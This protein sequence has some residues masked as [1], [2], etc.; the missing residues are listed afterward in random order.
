MT[1]ALPHLQQLFLITKVFNESHLHLKTWTRSPES[2][3]PVG[4]MSHQWTVSDTE[5]LGK[6]APDSMR[7]ALHV[8][9]EL[10]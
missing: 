9:F 6:E 10:D 1:N 2:S 3:A 8:L 4:D 7:R 5:D